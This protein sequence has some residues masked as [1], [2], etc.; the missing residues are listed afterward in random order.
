LFEHRR[1]NTWVVVPATVET[2]G[3]RVALDAL[4][5]RWRV[6]LT[7]DQASR[8]VA[9]AALLVQWS[10]RIN[11]TGARTALAVVEDHLPDSFAVASILGDA[12]S[13][14]DVGSGGGLPAIPLAI[15]RPALRV[16]LVE[17][18]AKKVAFLRTAVR[19][20]GLAGAA[21][22]EARRVEDVIAS[23]GTRVDIALSRA[24]F[25]PAEWL[26]VGRQLVRPGGRVLLLTVPD[27]VLAGRR[28]VYQD[29]RRVLIEVEQAAEGS[30]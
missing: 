28:L 1:D 5:S 25:P 27:T 26:E 3:A 11:L 10:A 24:T 23:G 14:I 29:G 8:L 6:P 15:L 19:E 21:Q 13:V 22:V 16:R 30:A 2:A 4:A 20:L 9:F 18:L 7:D 17:P 12:V